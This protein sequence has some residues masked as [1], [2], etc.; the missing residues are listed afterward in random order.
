MADNDT[1]RNHLGLYGFPSMRVRQIG[2]G[3]I[4]VQISAVGPEYVMTSDDAERL[5]QLI[6][7]AH[8]QPHD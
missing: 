3:S 8:G 2:A 6:K 7:E 5:V 1:T 4:G